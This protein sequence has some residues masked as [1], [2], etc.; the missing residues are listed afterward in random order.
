MAKSSTGLVMLKSTESHYFY[1]KKKNLK[2]EKLAIKKFDPVV[3]RTVVFKEAK[4][5]NPK[6]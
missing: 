1:V 3:N 2:G 5:P 4:M 6:K